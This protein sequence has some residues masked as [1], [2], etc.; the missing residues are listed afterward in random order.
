[1]ISPPVH[2]HP[3]PQQ[4]PHRSTTP[5]HISLVPCPPT[6]MYPHRCH[7]PIR[8][9]TSIHTSQNSPYPKTSTYTHTPTFPTPTH[10]QAPTPPP[11]PPSSLIYLS[12]KR[13]HHPHPP[14]STHALALQPIFNFYL[15]TPCPPTPTLAAALQRP[16][17]PHP[18]LLPPSPPS[19]S[20]GAAT[21]L[22][23][24]DPLH[25][26]TPSALTNQRRNPCLLDHVTSDPAK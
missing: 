22:H 10:P 6:H 11:F 1:M 3:H 26:S 16:L 2:I 25:T 7:Y 17:H 20:S 21:I 24:R 12:L 18:P 13:T 23:Y 4:Y 15:S 19:F 8:F 5:T 9:P 14:T